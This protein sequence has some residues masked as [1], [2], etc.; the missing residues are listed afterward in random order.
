MI[1]RDLEIVNKL[2]L[3]ARAS[4]VLAQTC[5][6]F[7]CAVQI[8][9]SGGKTADAKSIMALML[10]AASKGSFVTLTCD[11]ADEEQAMQT[12]A[13]VIANRFGEHE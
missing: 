1:S 4:S 3:H 2:G 10:M 7:S 13:D 5:C 6:R 12:I 11:G 9:K 8:S